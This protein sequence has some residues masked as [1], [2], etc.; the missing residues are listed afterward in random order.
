M[1][2]IKFIKY[3]PLGAVHGLLPVASIDR[4][5]WFTEERHG[6]LLGYSIFFLLSDT[7]RCNLA[8]VM[9]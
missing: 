7:Y 8:R 2:L 5:N 4:C 1:G 6:I 3:W 9:P